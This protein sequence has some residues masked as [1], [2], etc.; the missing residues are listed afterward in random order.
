VWSFLLRLFVRFVTALPAFRYGRSCVSLRRFVRLAAHLDNWP[1]IAFGCP[2]C[3]LALT[4]PWS[5]NLG[6]APRVFH[7]GSLC[8]WVPMLRSRLALRLGAHLVKLALR[9]VR[10]PNLG[11]AVLKNL[12]PSQ[13]WFLSV[14]RLVF[15]PS[16]PFVWS[17][18]LRLFMRFRYGH[19][20]VPLRLFV[21]FVTAV[22]AF[23][24][25]SSCI[26]L[27]PCAR[28][29]HPSCQLALHCIWVPLLPTRLALRC[30][31]AHIL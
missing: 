17:F 5:P 26:S 22:R 13:N 15:F 27:R 7:Y 21:R 29:R 18:S 11:E 1:C 4:S 12:P 24:Y 14:L 25:G 31:W 20:C 3:Q 8:V 6:Q 16:A 10:V 19:S 28:P 30:V 2:S 23:H 9:C